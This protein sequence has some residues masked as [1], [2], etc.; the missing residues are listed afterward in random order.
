VRIHPGLSF[1]WFARVSSN[2]ELRKAKDDED[3]VDC[4]MP[5]GPVGQASGKEGLESQSYSTTGVVI[6]SK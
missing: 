3:E 2:W 6:W 1:I 5:S 4:G